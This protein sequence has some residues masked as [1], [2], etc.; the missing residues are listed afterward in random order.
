MKTYRIFEEPPPDVDETWRHGAMFGGMCGYGAEDL[1]E[2]YF[3]AGDTL[4]DSVVNG[5]SSAREVVNPVLYVYRHGI[6]L[7]L[8]TIVRPAV[9]THRLGS[10]LSAFQEH[11]RQKYGEG[12]PS[13]ITLPI[14]AL[15]KY[16]RRS[17]VFRYETDRDG[18]NHQPLGD[19]GEFWVDLPALKRSM[20]I[21]RRSF[22]RVLWADRAGE[23]PPS[24][25][26]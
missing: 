19:D 23:I 6:E 12:V 2:S 7:Y 24:G 1:A 17:D 5:T 4:V 21:L 15:A 18:K 20:A 9:K 22:R 3:L 16:D 14:A 26:G 13:V 8:K 25:V 10:L 11:V